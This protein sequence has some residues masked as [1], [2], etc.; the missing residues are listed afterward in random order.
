MSH[1]MARISRFGGGDLLMRVVR[2][3]APRAMR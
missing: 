1:L 3:N 2:D